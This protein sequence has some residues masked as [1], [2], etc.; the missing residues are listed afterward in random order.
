MY[1][2]IPGEDKLSLIL[3]HRTR[4]YTSTT[5]VTN[6]TTIIS[7]NILVKQDK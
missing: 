5:I 1:S 3:I 6:I 4:D 2:D 7:S